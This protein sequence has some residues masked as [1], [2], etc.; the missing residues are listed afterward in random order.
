[1]FVLKSTASIVN[2]SDSLSLDKGE[3]NVANVTVA[4]GLGLFTLDCDTGLYE[5]VL[6][7]KI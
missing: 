3:F 1:M 7:C 6:M 4:L 2:L 5:F